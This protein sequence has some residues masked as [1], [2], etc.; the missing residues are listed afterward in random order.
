MPPIYHITHLQNLPNILNAERLWSDAQ[1]IRQGIANTS[2][3]H[4]HIKERR[5]KR[6][7]PLAAGGFLGEYVPF[8]FCN[9]S[10]MLY[11]IHAG[12]V[13][14]YTGGQQPIIHLVSNTEGIKAT[15]RPWAFTDRHAELAYANYFDDL[16][17]LDRIDWGVMPL[18]YWGGDADRRERRQ[19]E[20]LVHDWF[21]WSCVETIG[22]YNADL[23]RQVQAILKGASHQ[24]EVRVERGWYY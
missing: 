7:V 22:V 19:A 20:F 12:S 1:R 23:V 2:I 10:V 15:N 21:P 13:V 16:A 6:P 11:V 8:Y 5:L 24:P 17:F 18:Q 14:G 9:R 4:Q 3:G